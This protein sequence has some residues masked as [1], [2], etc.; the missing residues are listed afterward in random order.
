MGLN[1]NSRQLAELESDFK[2]EFV[3]SHSPTNPPA[4]QNHCLATP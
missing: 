1:L 2:S 3:Q 4:A